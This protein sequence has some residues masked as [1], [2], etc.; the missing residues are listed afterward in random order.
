MNT[1]PALTQEINDRHPTLEAHH[2]LNNIL[3]KRRNTEN[4]T[5]AEIHYNG[6]LLTI[7]TFIYP[8]TLTHHDLTDPKSLDTIL[9]IINQLC[10][11]NYDQL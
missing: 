4:P 1:L 7:M 9:N 10:P 2:I 6:K 3:I 5:I 8:V 11:T